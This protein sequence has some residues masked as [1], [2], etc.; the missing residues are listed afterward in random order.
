MADASNQ[1]GPQTI[2]FPLIG[3][4]TRGVDST[5]GQVFLN[6][7]F[8]ATA[9]PVTHEKEFFFIKR[10]G[11]SSLLVPA[12]SNNGRGVFFWNQTGKLYSVVGNKIYS[13]TTD[14][15]ITLSTTQG[16]CYFAI[17][18]PSAAIQ[19]LGVNDGTS[20]Y[21]IDKNDT[22]IVMNNVAITSSS[23]ANPTHITTTSNHNLQT[24]NKVIIRNHTGS[25][26]SINDTI[27]TVTVL[28]ATHFTIPVNVTAG[29][30][31]GTLGVFPAPNTGDLQY[32]DTFW[33]V[34][35]SDGT[36][37][38]C[39]P[40]DPTTWPTSQFIF[41]QMLPGIGIG[42]GRQNNV[43][44]A[45][46]DRHAQMFYDAANPAGSPLAN[47]EQAMQQIGCIAN[48]SIASQENTTY[49]V[50]STY[51]GGFSVYRL[52]GTSNLRDIGTPQVNR[53][54]LKNIFSVVGP[55]SPVQIILT[56]GTTWTV[57]ADFNPTNNTIEAIGGGG[58]ADFGNTAQG[59]SGGGGG[60]AYSKI[61]N[62]DP[63]GATTIPYT[64]G[65]GGTGGVS[66]GASVVAATD[67]T[68]NTSSLVA[69]H[70][71]AGSRTTGGTGGAAAGSTG[72]VKHSG[73]SGGTGNLV[74]PSGPSNLITGGGGGGGGAA[75]KFADGNNG[76]NATT[77]VVGSTT[78][79]V[80]GAGGQGDGTSGGFGG[81]IT[82]PGADGSEWVAAGSGGGGGGGGGGNGGRYGAGGGGGEADVFGTFTSGANGNQGVIVISYT[83]SVPSANSTISCYTLRIDGHIY[84]V[85]NLLTQNETW[86]YDQNLEIWTQWSDT[87]GN[88]V[89]PVLQTTQFAFSGQPFSVA[90]QDPT[91]GRL[92]K[93]DGEN[94]QDNGVNFPVN[95]TSLPL[96]FNTKK[97]KYY[98][99]VELIGDVQLT[100]T[101]VNVSY[102]DDDYQTFST[103]RVLDMSNVRAFSKMWGQSRRRVWKLSYSGNNKFRMY[104]IEFVIE[105]EAE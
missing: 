89:W 36:V 38:N 18:R 4:N 61:S 54:I 9:N 37:F 46:T 68:F 24:G 80:P 53:S 66:G 95:W 75:G 17:T 23:S 42:L 5:K 33:F 21:L 88:S 31:G 26:P 71:N 101:P 47:I 39:S 11:L 57:P 12:T 34:I 97:R 16:L 78:V 70:G 59:G 30:S 92:W 29:G 96:D 28:D 69:K 62:F 100:T 79:A 2:R 105:F 49:W 102:S 77:T 82:A 64:I 93:I 10:P 67:T 85:M 6:G 98:N 40:D 87:T 45:F 7:I 8:E 25:T 56:A 60:G 20:L 1:P 90:G 91:T 52:D 15:G 81:S 84:Y 3:N 51:N 13:N 86:V 22:V 103:P 72:T 41:P 32:M 48:N 35:K 50:S 104:G 58:A 27:F 63:L 74:G 76:A 99:N 14:L 94:T 65:A 73:G 43:L 55:A 19:Y 83:P 44:I